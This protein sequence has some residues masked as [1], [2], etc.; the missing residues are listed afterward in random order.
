MR[1][2]CTAFDRLHA[3]SRRGIAFNSGRRRL[4]VDAQNGRN[5][6]TIASANGA[7]DAFARGRTLRRHRR[8]PI[9]GE[10]CGTARAGKGDERC[11]KK[12]R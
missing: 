5:L 10:N 6:P 11:A 2:D 1:M 8:S 7:R 12:V 3:G 4:D 9:R